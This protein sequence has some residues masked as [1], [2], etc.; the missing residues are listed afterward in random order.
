MLASIHL[1]GIHP[2]FT[3][4]RTVALMNTTHGAGTYPGTYQSGLAQAEDERSF[5]VPRSQP[6]ERWPTFSDILSRLHR[7]GIY[8]H[9]DQ[10]AEFFLVHGLPVSLHH[11]PPQLQQRALFI[12]EHYQGD[13]A[14][15]EDE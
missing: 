11:V 10:L 9:A 5:T 15:L 14:R 4:F 7:A 8:I 2:A 1:S 13:M 3:R 12:N 6:A